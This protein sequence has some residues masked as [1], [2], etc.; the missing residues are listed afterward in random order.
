M[1]SILILF[2]FLIPFVNGQT[3]IET[4]INKF[5]SDEAFANASVSFEIFD[6]D[7]NKSLYSFD[8]NR[9]LITASTAKLFSTASALS[10]L[11]SNYKPVTKL[12]SEGELDTDGILHGNLWIRGGGDPSFGSRYFNEPFDRDQVFKNWVD[13]IVQSGI[14]KIEGRIIADASEF[15]YHGVPDGWQWIDMG[16]YYGAGPS[17]LTIYDNMIEYTFNIPANIGG[18]AKLIN[19]RPKIPALEFSNYIVA[20]ESKAD[21]AYIFGAPYQL[22]R[23]GLGSLPAG[24]SGF[25]VKGSIPDP[26]L[27]FSTELHEALVQNGI[28][29]IQDPTT[30]RFTDHRTNDSF[31]ADKQLIHKH[32]GRPLIDIIKETNFRSINLFAEHMLTMIARE[33]GKKGSTWEGLKY[34]DQ[35]WR[36]KIDIGGIRIADGSG[37]SRSNAISAHHFIQLLSYMIKSEN[38]EAFKNSLPISGKSGTLLNVCRGQKAEGRLQAKSGSINGVR[39]YAG[40]LR[41]DSGKLYAFALIVNNANCSSSVLKRKMEVLFNSLVS[42]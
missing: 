27:M 35:Y 39:S 30:T 41:G 20:A 38:G 31:Y 8:P 6:I 29:I 37:L 17:G 13:A 42:L 28:Q 1:K 15:G 5:T 40:Y 14:K 25:V 22:Q 34:V 3:S 26:E 24:S 12:Y 2:L 10:I 33:K 23:T 4:Q 16:N 18:A 32:T 7:A 19:I 11:G 36:D 21:N 9:A